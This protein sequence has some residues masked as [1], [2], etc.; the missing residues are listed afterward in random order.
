[1]GA[2]GKAVIHHEI[3][4][5]IHSNSAAFVSNLQQKH[6]FSDPMALPQIFLGPANR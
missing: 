1:M 5:F 4:L 2:C 6:L 3:N